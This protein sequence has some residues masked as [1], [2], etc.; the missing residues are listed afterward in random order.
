MTNVDKAVATLFVQK[1]AFD[2]ASFAES[3]FIDAPDAVPAD[4]RA[5]ISAARLAFALHVNEVRAKEFCDQFMHD[6]AHDVRELLGELD[7]E[8]KR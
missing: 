7:A 4:I 8:R 3:M 6:V 2:L 1:F 5:G